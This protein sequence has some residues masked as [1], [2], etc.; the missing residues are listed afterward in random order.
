M[1]SVLSPLGL[2]AGLGILIPVLIHLWN[3]KS[4][5]TL[6]IGS[7][8]LLGDP[9]NQR[10]SSLRITNW[11]LLLL[12]CLLILCIALILTDPV[13]K[14]SLDVSERPG[15]ILV[16]KGDFKNLWNTQRKQL[17][18]LL[19]KGYEIHDFDVQFRK[20]ELAD[21]LSV[22]SSSAEEPLSYFALL[23]QVETQLEPGRKVYLYVHNLSARFA[24]EVPR[25]H[26][27]LHWNMLPAA[28]RDTTW[29]AGV[30]Q[31]NDQSFVSSTAH[32][33]AAGTYYRTAMLKTG[34]TAGMAVDT[35]IL[36]IQIY[37]EPGSKDAEYVQAAVGAIRQYTRRKIQVRRIRNLQETKDHALVFWLSGKAPS[38]AQISKL[39]EGTRFYYYAGGKVQSPASSF[40]DLSGVSLEHSELYK[41]TAYQNTSGQVIWSDA[42]GTPVLS[43]EIHRGTQVFKFYSRFRPDWNNLVWSENMV[44]FLLPIVLPEANA[45]IAFE[46]DR[47]SLAALTDPKLPGAEQGIKGQKEVF[48]QQPLSTWFWWVAFVLVILERWLSYRKNMRIQ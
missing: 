25:L 17:D 44:L 47:R 1:F 27:N 31:V 28:S 13:H 40:K 35:S 29:S 34:D 36:R 12:R 14:A 24:S 3:I 42:S 11:P 32:S 22:F 9:S 30:Y 20:L 16:E 37:A 21:T 10:S 19:A 33:S 39:P 26:L 46:Q 7:I 48:V 43:T 15:W 2:L 41:R 8:A 5:K 38:P 45:G 6:K 18:S 23:K 4:G